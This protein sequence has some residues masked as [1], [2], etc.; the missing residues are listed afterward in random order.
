MVR[1][2]AHLVSC[3][4]A[5]TIVVF[6]VIIFDALKWQHF[7]KCLPA[8]MTVELI[9]ALWEVAFSGLIKNDIPTPQSKGLTF[10]MP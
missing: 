5:T 10:F 6:I 1:S 4:L 7:E 9:K 2:F 8:K 3:F